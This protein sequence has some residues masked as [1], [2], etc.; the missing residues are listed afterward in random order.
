MIS[1]KL[2]KDLQSLAAGESS[3][4]EVQDFANE[5]YSFFQHSDKEDLDGFPIAEYMDLFINEN[6]KNG[7]LIFLVV[8][9][10]FGYYV[11]LKGYLHYMNKAPF[12][13]QHGSSI[14]WEK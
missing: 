4:K 12:F 2:M 5:V 14:H 3:L 11:D 6:V 8:A 1:D 7:N 10:Q 9:M 13:E